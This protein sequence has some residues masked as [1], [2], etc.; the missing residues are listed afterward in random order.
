[1]LLTIEWYLVGFRRGVPECKLNWGL[2]GNYMEISLT[3]IIAVQ[4]RI[5]IM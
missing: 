1:M 2:V 5:S 3:P 4:V